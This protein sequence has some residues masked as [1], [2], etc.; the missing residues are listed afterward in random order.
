MVEQRRYLWERAGF[1]PNPNIRLRPE[2]DFRR[3][4]ELPEGVTAESL[5]G[6]VG[7]YIT[8]E[9]TSLPFYIAP[10]TGRGGSAGPLMLKW[11]GGN[12]TVFSDLYVKGAGIADLESALFVLVNSKEP[13]LSDFVSYDWERNGIPS[14]YYLQGEDE[15]LGVAIGADAMLD[16][17]RSVALHLAGV[18]TRLPVVGFDILALPIDGDLISIEELIRDGWPFDPAKDNVPVVTGWARRYPYTFRDLQHAF[19]NAPRHEQNLVTK[20]IVTSLIRHLT[21]EPDR[22][23]GNWAA[24]MMAEIDSWPTAGWEKATMEIFSWMAIMYGRLHA[25]LK[26]LGV[27]HEMLTDH[28]SLPLA[29]LSDNSHVIFR[30]DEPEESGRS[31][32][33]WQERYELN[34]KCSGD[35]MAGLLEIIDTGLGLRQNVHSDRNKIMLRQFYRT[36]SVSQV[37]Q[38]FRSWK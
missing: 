20:E 22:K 25:R 24:L 35:H 12:P 27:Y 29:E 36:Y 9:E 28:N 14:F 26:R 21:Y 10:A 16:S 3:M 2:L 32:R 18:R 13:H 4:Y 19:V 33:D 38:V 31:D 30:N 7:G 34:L 15:S 1:M 5:A 37:T 23:T 8:R 6:L 11:A 17:A